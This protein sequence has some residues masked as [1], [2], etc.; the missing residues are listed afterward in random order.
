MTNSMLMWQFTVRP[1]SQCCVIYI[2]FISHDTFNNNY[3]VSKTI[4]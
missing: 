4:Q 3:N 2:L 1:K